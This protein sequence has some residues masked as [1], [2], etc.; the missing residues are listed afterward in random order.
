MSRDSF[1]TMQRI[2]LKAQLE[3]ILATLHIFS[4]FA[5][6]LMR[7]LFHLCFPY[8]LKDV[9]LFLVSFHVSLLNIIWK[10]LSFFTLGLF[11]CKNGHF[12]PSIPITGVPHKNA[13]YAR[14]V[15]KAKKKKKTLCCTAPG[16]WQILNP[17]C[18]S[19]IRLTNGSLQQDNGSSLWL[20]Y[21]VQTVLFVM[22]IEV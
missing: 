11:F 18:W 9:S 20:Y 16:K 1:P 4:F 10:S 17:A 14:C 6:Q 21:C 13:G 3:V 19:N 2:R 12:H 8:I 22:V 15:W 5:C 7:F